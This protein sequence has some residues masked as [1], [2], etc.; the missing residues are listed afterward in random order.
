[1]SAACHHIVCHINSRAGWK[2]AGPGVGSRAPRRA[3]VG[4]AFPPG[5]RRPAAEGGPEP[6]RAIAGGAG[7]GPSPFTCAPRS[8]DREL[9]GRGRAPLLG[10]PRGPPAGRHRLR[11]LVSPGRRDRVAL[12]GPRRS[13]SHRLRPPGR[14]EHRRPVHRRRRRPLRGRGGVLRLPPRT[15]RAPADLRRRGR[16]ARRQPGLP[17]DDHLPRAGVGGPNARTPRGH[18]G[19]SFWLHSY[20]G[21]PGQF[22]RTLLGTLRVLTILPW[23]RGRTGRAYRSAPRSSRPPSRRGSGRAR[24]TPSRGMRSTTPTLPSPGPSR[25]SPGWPPCAPATTFTWRGGAMRR[26]LRRPRPLRGSG[27]TGAIAPEATR[28]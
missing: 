12:P 14:P 17:R 22:G 11:M 6:D 8:P 2:R 27:A 21:S 24:G 4:G 18:A 23:T 25:S 28:R 15:P 20:W 7:S 5:G 19:A 3:E 26:Y 1:M 10:C 13:R 16:P 9:T